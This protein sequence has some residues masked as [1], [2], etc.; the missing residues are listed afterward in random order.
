MIDSIR[1]DIAFIGQGD[2]KRASRIL[3]ELD[4]DIKIKEFLDSLDNFLSR[5]SETITTPRTSISS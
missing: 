4:S 3:D 2:N 5:W 1:I